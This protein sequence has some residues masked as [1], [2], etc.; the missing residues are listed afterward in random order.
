MP[1]KKKKRKKKKKARND[2]RGFVTLSIA[3][4]VTATIDQLS[5][6]SKNDNNG[7]G[8]SSKKEYTC[9]KCNENVTLLP[10][11]KKQIQQNM[12]ILC[13]KC[14]V[15]RKRKGLKT[16][17]KSVKHNDFLHNYEGEREKKKQKQLNI[18]LFV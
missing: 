16:I 12:D 14:N 8:K 11:I 7:D 3:T 2:N 1:P 9:S 10:R 17:P 13:N 4:A 5:N 18:A 6:V 15:I